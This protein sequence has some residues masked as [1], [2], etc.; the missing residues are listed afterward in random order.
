MRLYQRTAGSRSRLWIL[1]VQWH[2][3][4]RL[5]SAPQTATV[6]IT[7]NDCAKYF[8]LA[9]RIQK[10]IRP[11]NSQFDVI[12]YFFC[13]YLLWGAPW[14]G[15]RIYFTFDSDQYEAISM[16]NRM[17]SSIMC[18]GSPVASSMTSQIGTSN[19]HGRYNQEWLYHMFSSCLQDTKGDPSQVIQGRCGSSSIVHDGDHFCFGQFYC[20]SLLVVCLWVLRKLQ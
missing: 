5:R 12:D 3:R 18:L 7:M 2:P 6:E 8:G 10:V 15:R 13:F 20:N 9:S 14:K 17:M 16:Y 19:G 1:V 11:R 4:W